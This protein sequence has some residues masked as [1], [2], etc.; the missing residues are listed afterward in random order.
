MQVA[1]HERRSRHYIRRVASHP[2]QLKPDMM[3]VELEFGD[4]GLRYL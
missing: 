3:G 2:D 1:D 4:G